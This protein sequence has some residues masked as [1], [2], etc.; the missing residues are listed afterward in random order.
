M[1]IS[2]FRFQFYIGGVPNKQEGL[3]VTQ[4]FTGCIENLYF[5]S[6]NVNQL[7]K[8]IYGSGNGWGMQ[9]Y[10]KVN[11]QDICPVSVS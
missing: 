8:E 5:N 10:E 11:V 1:L 6:T 7:V 2:D 3:I 9:T 4:N